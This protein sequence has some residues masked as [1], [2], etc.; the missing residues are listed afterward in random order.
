MW[1]TSSLW[2]FPLHRFAYL[3]Y[4]TA[5]SNPGLSLRA[6]MHLQWRKCFILQLQFLIMWWEALENIRVRFFTECRA[7]WYYIRVCVCVSERLQMSSEGSAMKSF[8]FVGEGWILLHSDL[9]LTGRGPFAWKTVGCTLLINVLTSSKNTLAETPRR[10][11]PK[12]WLPAAARTSSFIELTIT[13]TRTGPVV[14]H[15]VLHIPW[16]Q[17]WLSLL[18][19]TLARTRSHGHS[20]L[21]GWVGSGAR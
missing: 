7:T 4:V 11:W 14:C 21:S 5:S 3:L 16:G 15:W 17:W 2:G 6:R 20:Q 9:R 19:S 10:N 18:R 8:L 13:K 1:A 12:A